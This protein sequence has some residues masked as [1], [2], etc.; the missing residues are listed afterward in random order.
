MVKLT[1]SPL[2]KT[3]IFDLDGTLLKHNG[4]KNNGDE[5]LP[6]VKELFSQIPDEDFIL[7]LTA[8]ADEVIKDTEIFLR[9]QGLRFDKILNNIPFGERILLNDRKPSGLDMA[10]A[11]NLER[12]AGCNLEVMIDDRL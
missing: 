9:N 5:L 11:I 12:D 1:L 4:Y 6:G 8:R 7:I 2:P 3:W 10:Y